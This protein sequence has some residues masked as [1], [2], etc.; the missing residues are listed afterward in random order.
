MS[1]L[2]SEVGTG[3][4]PMNNSERITVFAGRGTGQLCAHCGQ[5]I[6]GS[7]IEYEVAAQEQ[8]TDSGCERAVVRVHL[9]CHDAWRATHRG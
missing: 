4:Q 5:P 6:L 8:S 7:E 1:E 3:A 9:R 2:P